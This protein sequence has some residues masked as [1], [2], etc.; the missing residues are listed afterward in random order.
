[1]TQTRSRPPLSRNTT[2]ESTP[3]Y[4]TELAVG[5][6]SALLILAAVTALL[7]RSLKW[8]SLAAQIN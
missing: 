5:L 6:G 7:L 2:T 4:N 1:M 3:P 8:S